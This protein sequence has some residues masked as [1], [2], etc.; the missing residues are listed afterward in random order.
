MLRQ[1]RM[2][3]MSEYQMNENG[4]QGLFD[5]EELQ[6]LQDQFGRSMGVYLYCLDSAGQ[7]I[8]HPYGSLDDLNQIRDLMIEEQL[9]AMY[10]RVSED[11][12][13]D[14]A[15]EEAPAPGLM[16]GAVS[17]KLKGQAVIT[18]ILFGI[19]EDGE[20]PMDERLAPLRERITRDHFEGAL[21][22]LRE[23]S[24]HLMHIRMSGAS[25]Q[26]ETRRSRY[27]E[28]EMSQTLR[29]MEAI[30][31]VVQL[32]DRDDTIERIMDTFIGSISRFMGLDCSWINQLG[33]EDESKMDVVAEWLGQGITSPYDYTRGLHRPSYL[34]SDSVLALST[35]SDSMEMQWEWDMRSAGLTAMIIHPIF[36]K[37]R[38]QMYAVFGQ[39]RRSRV[40]SVEEIRYINDSMKIL[41]S[42]ITR[43]VQNLSLN[44]SYASLEAVLD[45]VGTSIYVREK[46]TGVIPFTNRSL[47]SN[48]RTELEQNKLAELFESKIPENSAMGSVEIYYEDKQH[49]YDLYYTDITWMN[50]SPA[51][52]CS[53]HEE[54]E[55]KQYQK[56][57]EQ[58][59]YTDYLTGLYNRMC[60]ER[61]LA[62]YIDEAKKSG[63]MGALMYLDLDDFKHIN[64]GLGHKYG[65]VLLQSIAHSVNRIEGI[66]GTCYRMG[67]DEFVIILPPDKFEHYDHVLES[68]TEVFS[69]PWFLK[70]TDYYCTMSMGVIK[71]PEQGEDVQDLIKKADVTMYEAKHGGK[72]RIAEYNSENDTISSK[73]LDMERHMREA[74]KEEYAEFEVYYQPIT[75]ISKEGTACCGAEALLRWNSPDLGFISPG[76][77][78]PLAEYLELIVPIGKHVLLEACKACKEWNDSGYP[79]HK[80]NVNLSVVQLLQADIVE[81]IRDALEKT[82]LDP[83]HLTLEVT[84][85]LAINDMAKMKSVLNDIHGLGVRLALDDFG[86]GYSSMNH[87]R[88]LPLDVIKVDQSFVR[89]LSE[90]PYSQAFVRM[91][92]TLAQTLD[93]N[94]CVEGI[95]TSEQYHVLEGMGVGMVQG[96]YFD[97]PMPKAQF[98]EKYIRK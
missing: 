61:D 87:L 12:L 85:S 16:Y 49:W 32:L 58:L 5:L 37:D 23:G 62:I 26:A 89:E 93:M 6:C 13:E 42:I 38:V 68:I 10:Y 91:V 18:W 57:I 86:T 46:K 9:E 65:D 41:Q 88:E 60:C 39:C 96:F 69:R 11:S 75:D 98:D 15:Y 31:E 80:V 25:A 1:E 53:I 48:F 14:Q 95:E 64:D 29:R 45:N 24:L 79:E 73:R 47:R 70:D 81:E 97:R 17:I 55:K 82:G 43:R 72:N 74:S 54:T 3:S 83:S 51:I 94:V 71:F 59:A 63:R 27:S 56:R 76:E 40:W 33:M 52:L 34:Y 30:T 8:T 36:V 22:L 2:R 67:G 28:A 66:Q 7:R 92:T 21:D 4:I 35:G 19:C 77:F 50:G 90:E 20:Q 78:I 44:S 84:E